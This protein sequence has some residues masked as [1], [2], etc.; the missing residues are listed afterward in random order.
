VV[1]G[2]KHSINKSD[3][4]R[5]TLLKRPIF[6]KGTRKSRDILVSNKLNLKKN[7]MKG[8]CIYIKKRYSIC[9]VVVVTTHEPVVFKTLFY[10]MTLTAK[11]LYSLNNN[12]SKNGWFRK[13]QYLRY[14]CVYMATL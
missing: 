5:I 6:Q 10:N 13:G 8:G 9:R 7:V 2:I 12:G 1:Y 11:K 3:H 14:A 4:T